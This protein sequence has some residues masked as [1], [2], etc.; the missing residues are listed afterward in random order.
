VRR[1]G[2]VPKADL[3]VLVA[4]AVGLT[5]PSRYEGFGAPVLEAMARG[6]PV[7]A[8]DA[9]AL[10]E[11]VAEAGILVAPDQPEDWARAMRQ[12]LDDPARRA[13]LSR[14]GLARAAGYGWDRAARAQL[15]AWRVAAVAR[16]T[17]RRGASR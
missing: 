6:C 2:R 14:A 8:A 3:G 7:V 1:V 10:P 17:S 12:L 16:R 9:T 11:V 15:D 5:F 4:G 13:E